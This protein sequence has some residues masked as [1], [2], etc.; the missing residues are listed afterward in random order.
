MWST[1]YCNC[2]LP[3]TWCF[4]SRLLKTGFFVPDLF[5]FLHFSP[6]KNSGW[7]S[8]QAHWYAYAFSTLFFSDKGRIL[9]STKTK[10]SRTTVEHFRATKKVL[11]KSQRGFV[12]DL[13]LQLM[14]IFI[15]FYSFHFCF[16]RALLQLSKCCFVTM[17][18]EVF[19]KKAFKKYIYR[20]TRNITSYGLL[21]FDS[22]V[23]CI[24]ECCIPFFFYLISIGYSVRLKKN[25]NFN[26]YNPK[27]TRSL[28][29][30]VLRPRITC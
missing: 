15:F 24:N 25:N 14:F 18:F 28:R 29:Y 3:K 2:C 10:P 19:L 22:M 30:K 1:I 20:N 26:S 5:A 6:I 27:S 16:W 7:F 21:N 23:C 11:E 8:A 13:F 4:N 9:N 17:L 12:L